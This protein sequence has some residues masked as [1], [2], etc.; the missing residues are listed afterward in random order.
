VR[1]VW[2]ASAA[3][4]HQCAAPAHARLA[5][6]LCWAAR[7][8]PATSWATSGTTTRH[9]KTRQVRAPS[10]PCGLPALPA[11]QPRAV[12]RSFPRRP[13][14]LLWVRLPVVAFGVAALCSAPPACAC[15]CGCLL[16]HLLRSRRGW[17]LWATCLPF[18]AGPN[19]TRFSG[20]WLRKWRCLPGCEAPSLPC[21]DLEERPGTCPPP[22]RDCPC[23]AGAGSDGS[24]A[25]REAADARRAASLPQP[26]KLPFALTHLVMFRMVARSASIKQA[27]MALGMRYPAVSKQLAALEQVRA[28]GGTEVLRC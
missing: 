1:V 3:A 5:T 12:K 27:A 21:G 9:S 7:L 14:G 8:A 22:T 16:G 6:R 17:G 20:A 11:A 28:R 15:S 24:G 4:S 10:P 19:A 25:G 13:S 23:D 26:D 2:R 18:G